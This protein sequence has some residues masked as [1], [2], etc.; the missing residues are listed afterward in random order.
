MATK[1]L[2]P[3]KINRAEE[4]PALPNPDS[5]VSA[6]VTKFRYDIQSHIREL[7]R[8]IM[9]ANDEIADAEELH[10]RARLK[11]MKLEK[12]RAQLQQMLV[13]CGG[14]AIQARK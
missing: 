3:V 14:P 11:K 8:E 12:R 9:S 7:N 13:V 1:R 5:D 10:R 4:V 6:T 2:T